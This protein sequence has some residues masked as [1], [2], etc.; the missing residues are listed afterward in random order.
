[1]KANEVKGLKVKA[2]IKA[3]GLNR[4]H[5]RPVIRVRT[6]LKGGASIYV[7]NHAA[8]LISR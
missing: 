6:G 4:N 8:R 5:S 1:M 2:G 7:S 3:G